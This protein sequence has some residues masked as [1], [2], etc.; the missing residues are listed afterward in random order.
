MVPDSAMQTAGEEK[1]SIALP[2][3]ARYNIDPSRQDVP[4]VPIVIR[5]E[6]CSTCL[7]L[8]ILIKS[9]DIILLNSHVVKLPSKHLYLYQYT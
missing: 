2:S 7:L 9:P 4:T 5:F 8:Y 1:T 6:A 3:M